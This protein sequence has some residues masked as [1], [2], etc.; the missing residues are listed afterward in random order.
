LDKKIATFRKFALASTLTTY[1]LIFIGGLVRVTGAGLGCPDWPKCFGRWIPPIHA[2]QIPQDFNAASFNFTLAWIEYVN[3]LIGMI[4]GIL[5]LITAILA[6][7][8]YRNTKRIWVPALLAVMLV[9]FQGWYGSVV[10]ASQLQPI[11]VSVHLL[12]ALLIVSLLIY[13]TQNAYY[14]EFGAGVSTSPQQKVLKPFVLSLWGLAIIQIVLGTQVRSKIEMILEEFPLLMGNDLIMRIGSI[15]IFHMILGIVL[16][17]LT[18]FIVFKSFKT[19]SDFIRASSWIIVVLI[20]IQILTG[21]TL[22]IR[23]LPQVL[24]LFHLWIASLII[25]VVLILYTELS[26]QN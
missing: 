25:G 26:N 20:I 8:Y 18:I 12:L 6:I 10:V 15:N 9:A 19:G 13:I 24:Q 2:S 14:I 17:L 21:A 1:F 22:E 11:T 7:K 23:G 16:L 5:I 3:R 4:T